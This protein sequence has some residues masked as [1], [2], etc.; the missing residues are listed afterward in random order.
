M[1]HRITVLGRHR[2]REWGLATRYA[3]SWVVGLVIVAVTL[4]LAEGALDW[5]TAW[6]LTLLCRIPALRAAP[7]CV[8]EVDTR[9]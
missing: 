9:Q 1:L 2:L 6:L 3:T 5:K 8:R 7:G 4:A